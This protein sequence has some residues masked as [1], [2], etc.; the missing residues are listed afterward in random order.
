MSR[1]VLLLVTAVLLLLPL[2][3]PSAAQGRAPGRTGLTAAETATLRE[4]AAATWG[5]F[6]DMVD[7]GTGLPTD[8]LRADG[9]RDTETSTS[10]IGVYLWSAVAARDL[11]VIAPAEARERIAAVLTTLES[12]ERHEPSGQFFNWYDHTTGEK[13]TV[14]PPS[15]APLTP[16]LS[17]VDN[18]WLAAGLR[19]VSGAVPELSDRADEL[20]DGMDF[21]FYYRPEQNRIL[22]HAVPSTGEEACCYDTLVSEARIALYLGIAQGQIPPEAYYGTWRT[23]PDSCDWSWQETRPGSGRGRATRSYYGVDVFEGNY[24]YRG[25]HLVPSWGGSMFEALMPSLVVP[26]AQWGRNSWGMNHPLTVAAQITHGLHEAEYGYW[27]F[28][29][30]DVPLP[31][32]GI[33]YEAMGVDGAGMDPGGYPSNLDRT[34]VD[35]GFEG[36][37]GRP[38]QPVPEPAAFT[39]GVVTPHAAFLGLPFAPGPAMDNLAALRGDFDVYTDDRGFFDSVNVDTGAVTGTYLSLDQGMVMAAIA[40]TLLDGRIQEYF[41]DRDLQRALHPMLARERFTAAPRCAVI[42][43]IDRGDV[44]NLA[45]ERL[46]GRTPVSRG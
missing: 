34:T 13:L 15:G 18:G 28:S 5:S 4:Y 25:L 2:A 40:N 14:W 9:S 19:V 23:F 6:E 41:V 38:A 11:G 33:G 3:P 43:V 10:N 7:P 21:G 32:G 16:I 1:R 27:G 24:E 42:G 26:E 45:S 35:A 31:G 17:S 36:C 39:N 12:M 22:F 46:C 29:P 30:A 37:P 20:A 44:A 8:R